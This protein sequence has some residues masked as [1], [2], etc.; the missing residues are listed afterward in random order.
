MSLDWALVVELTIDSHQFIHS[1]P[2]GLAF[3]GFRLDIRK[4]ER[5]VG[6]YS[7]LR[8]LCG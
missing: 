1:T 5:I 6:F 2:D 7:T 8:T 3:L 4:E